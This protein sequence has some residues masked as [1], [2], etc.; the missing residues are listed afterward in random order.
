MIE[1]SK[2]EM[3]YLTS[4]GC[5]WHG[6]IMA[7]LSRAHYYAKDCEKVNSLLNKY[8]SQYIKKVN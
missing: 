8:R 6:D 7:S 3:K 4:H 2:K 5:R 1:I